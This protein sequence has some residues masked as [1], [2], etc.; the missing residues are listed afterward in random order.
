MDKKLI[1][2]CF[3]AI[4]IICVTVVLSFAGTNDALSQKLAALSKIEESFTFAVIGDNRS[5]DDVYRELIK[6]SMQRRPDFV[7]NTGDM[8]RSAEET[9][10]TNFWELSKPIIVPY[11]LT[12]GNHDVHD[13]KSEELYKKQVDLPGNKLYYS[14]TAGNS[15]FIVLDSN[16][17]GQEKK[18]IGKQYKWLELALSNSGYKHKFVFVH[19]PL[20][21]ELGIGEHYGASIDRYPGERDRLQTLFVKHKVT[22]VFCGHEHL[23]LRKMVDGVTHIITGGGGAPLYA[24]EKEGGFYHFILITVDGDRVSGEVI[25]IKGKVKDT[26]QL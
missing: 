3:T 5:G 9:Y 12:V 17:P 16:I 10:W 7:I 23:Y 24:D 26:F 1:R 20:Y 8:V 4:L 22:I 18:I 2:I 21:P 13:A 6:Q 11:F 14:F 15:L 19:H 25:D